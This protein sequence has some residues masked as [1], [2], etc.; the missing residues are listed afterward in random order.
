MQQRR[1]FAIGLHEQIIAVAVQHADMHMHAATGVFLIG[2]CHKGGVQMMIFRHQPYQ[3]F[4]R[5]RVIAGQQHVIGM[6]QIYL[7][8]AG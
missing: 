7:E 6:L 8:L 1:V 3:A 2:L 5:Q 4:Q